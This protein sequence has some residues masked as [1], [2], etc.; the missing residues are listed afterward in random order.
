MPLSVVSLRHKQLRSTMNIVTSNHEQNTCSSENESP[1]LLPT[2]SRQLEVEMHGKRRG[3]NFYT[4]AFTKS[5]WNSQLVIHKHQKIFSSLLHWNT[6]HINPNEF[7]LQILTLD[8][9]W[10]KHT[11]TKKK[12]SNKKHCELSE[13][14]Y[15]KQET[16]IECGN[17]IRRHFENIIDEN[18]CRIS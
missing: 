11:H 5:I 7:K 8:F 9:V 13:V 1:S 12:L 6:N 2:L 17:S 16:R 3:P 15:F 4:N 18:T 14:K 10:E